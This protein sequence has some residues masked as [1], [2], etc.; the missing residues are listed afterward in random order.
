M[1][2]KIKTLSVLFSN[3]IICIGA[4]HGIGPI[5]LI[6]LFSI[7]T[8]IFEGEIAY[9]SGNFPDFSFS[10]SYEDMIMYFILYS[11]V[12]QIVFTISLLNIFKKSIKISLRLIGILLMLF[13]F[14]LISKNLNIDDLSFFSFVTGIPFLFF[15]FWEISSHINLKDI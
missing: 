3:F 2:K 14:L 11:F 10:N 7:Y 12:G 1:I 15:I 4:G 5:I 9:N 6:E 13:G 8:L